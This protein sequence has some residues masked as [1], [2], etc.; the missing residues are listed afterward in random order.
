MDANDVK[1]KKLIY[2]Y[3]RYIL[4]INII[5]IRYITIYSTE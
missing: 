4:T 2:L 3:H 1:R 5:F